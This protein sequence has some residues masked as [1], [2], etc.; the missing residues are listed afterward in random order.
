MKSGPKVVPALLCF[1]QAACFAGKS[2]ALTGARV[3]VSDRDTGFELLSREQ[4]V[5]RRCLQIIAFIPSG[6]FDLRR[7]YADAISGAPP[8]TTG[9]ALASFAEQITQWGGWY[10]RRCIEVRGL[11]AREKSAPVTPV[12]VAETAVRVEEPAAPQK[13]A[14]PTPAARETPLPAEKSPP[15]RSDAEDPG[16]SSD[17]TGTLRWQRCSRGQDFRAGTCDGRALAGNWEAAQVYCKQLS[18]GGHTYRLPSLPEL[19]HLLQNGASGA[20]GRIDATRFPA[21]PADAFWTQ[22]EYRS[23]AV[24]VV[25]FGSGSAYP[26]GKTNRAFV[27]CVAE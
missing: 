26:Y 4:V 12:R 23:V 19:K 11:P 13:K 9:L 10:Y 1:A 22:S 20:D 8:G 2:A 25:D 18:L 7:A 6:D 24:W 5:G 17:G 21:T 27:R 14:E 15:K 16:V 3:S